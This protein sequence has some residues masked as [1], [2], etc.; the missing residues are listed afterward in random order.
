MAFKTSVQKYSGSICNLELGTGENT[1]ALGGQNVFP[2]YSF[3]G[4]TGSGTK[5]GLEILDVYPEN[6]VKGLKEL[7]GSVVGNTVEW[8]KYV[9]EK[10][11][12]DFICLRFEGADPNGLNKSVEECA[13]LAKEVANAVKLPLVIA[14]TQNYEKDLKLF[15]KV[16]EELE[17][18]N[19]L[20][21][22]AV[23]DNY[24]TVAAA[25]VT[26]YKHKVA[27]ESSVDINLAKQLN[28]LIN[29]LEVKNENIVMNVGTAPVGYG[30]EYVASTI[31]RIRLAA[32]GQNDKTLQMPII[33]PVAFDTWDVKESAST[34]EDSPE[35]GCQEERG[36]AMEVSTAASVIA[37]GS[38][39]V[40]LRHP[41]SAETIRAFVN[42]LK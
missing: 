7:Y 37:V 30:F 12:P 28:I 22:S 13:T 32:L 3:D 17:G 34:E 29:Q 24:K 15:E 33:T 39:A 40:V 10:F 16:A 6:W 23:E 38:D 4:D 27:A 20:L 35:W 11:A 36:I 9:E 31:D 26:A 25:G 42:N 1:L 41:R 14:G 8:A 5:I 21:L 18:K 2:F 19:V